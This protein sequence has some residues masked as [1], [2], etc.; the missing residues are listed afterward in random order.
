MNTAPATT[1]Q[2][3]F[4]TKLREDN[5]YR[6]H[7]DP[8]DRV[9]DMGNGRTMEVNDDFIAAQVAGHAAYNADLD[10]ITKSEASALIDALKAW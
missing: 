7:F 1:A 10:G 2:I 4:I 8:T 5:A 3:N 6:A 9:I